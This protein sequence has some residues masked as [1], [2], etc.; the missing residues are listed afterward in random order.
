MAIPL[1]ARPPAKQQ[2][3]KAGEGSPAAKGKAGYAFNT[4]QRR[5]LTNSSITTYKML[6]GCGRERVEAAWASG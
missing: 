5:K 3:Q 6:V 4:T 1:P 2:Q